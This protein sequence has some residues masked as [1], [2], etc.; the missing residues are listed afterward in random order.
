EF[1]RALRRQN[2]VIDAYLD[3]KDAT[4]KGKMD[5]K[6]DYFIL[7]EQPDLNSSTPI[8]ESDTRFD[9]KTEILEKIAGMRL[10]AQRLG[11]TIVPVRRFAELTGYQLPQG[12]RSTT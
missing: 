6:T 8:K 2:I 11:V 4:V 12:P 7:G 9:R 3:L 1:M 5:H 10:E